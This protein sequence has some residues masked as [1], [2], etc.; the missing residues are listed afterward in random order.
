[1]ADAGRPVGDDAAAAHLSPIQSDHINYTCD[2]ERELT[3]TG[4]RPLQPTG[5]PRPYNH[6]CA[7]ATGTPS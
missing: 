7:A 6:F 5:H 2:I 1:M 4:R 3:R